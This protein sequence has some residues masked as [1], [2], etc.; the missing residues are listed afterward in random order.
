MRRRTVFAA[1]AGLCSLLL[2]CD[3]LSGSLPSGMVDSTLVQHVPYSGSFTYTVDPG[4]TPRDVYFVFTN[5][6][7][8]Q[9]ASQTPSVSGSIAVDGARVPAPASQQL[10]AYDSAPQTITDRIAEFNRNPYAYLPPQSQFGRPSAALISAT[11]AQND[12]AGVT[13][14]TFY[15]DLD[16]N[17]NGTSP[18]LATCQAVVGPVTFADGRRRT[19]SVWVANA[20]SSEITGPMI[21]ALTSRFLQNPESLNEI[22]HWDTAVVGEPWGQQSF[23][24]LIPWDPNNTVTVLLTHLNASYS[25]AVVVGFYW[26]KDN[27]IT[28][29][30]PG[31]NQRIMF[32]IDSN[33]YSM[34]H[35]AETVWDLANYWPKMVFSALAHEF[36]HMIQFYQKQALRGASVGTDTWINEMCSML[37]EDLVADPAKLNVEGPRGLLTAGAGSPPISLGRIPGFNASSNASL[38]VAG[39]GFG[40]TQYSVAYAFGAWLARNYGGPDLLRRIVQSSATDSSAVVDAAGAYSGTTESMQRLLERWA[41]SVLLSD[42]TTAPPGYRYNTGGW[43][44][45]TIGSVG[46]NLGSID[47]FNYS[48]QLTTY[49]STAAI[50]APPYYSSNVY[51]LAAS[52][53]AASRT[54]S[55]TLPTGTDMS[56]VLK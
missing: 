34:L 30:L 14:G 9:N 41:A 18:I 52:Q 45:F 33:L 25:G 48:P 37:M 36:Q 32:Y 53:L 10:P 44:S 55:V 19:L 16:A 22:Y 12:T 11:P 43:S 2:S 56:V 39:S 50:P 13:T 35:G 46:F 15:T 26:A 23:S 38:A 54:F 1:L 42:T 7:L 8:S 51:F 5:P 31:S 49:S 27:F 3:P 21:T 4:A 40:L 28:A 17:G 47:I 24:N 6:S 29:S 20:Y